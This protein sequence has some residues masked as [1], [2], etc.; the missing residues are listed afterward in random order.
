MARSR[1]G[2]S[3]GA[4]RKA[5]KPVYHY[6]LSWKPGETPDRAEMSRA[7]DESLKKLG[8]EDRQALIVAHN[9]TPHRHVHVI[10]NRVDPETGRTRHQKEE[11][12][13]LGREH[14][15]SAREY[16]RGVRQTYAHDGAAGG[17]GSAPGTA[18]CGEGA[19]GS[20]ES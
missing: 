6:A 18:E 19:R 11:R 2:P 9:D 14:A 5:A 12:A 13:A 8:M 16:E 10:V 7:V 20:I 3:P 17:A 1:P 4:G 15:E